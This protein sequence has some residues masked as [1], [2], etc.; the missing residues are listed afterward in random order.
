M[1][2][3]I[4]VRLLFTF[5]FVVA[6]TLSLRTVVSS[7]QF[8]VLVSRVTDPTNF[9]LVGMPP[10]HRGSTAQRRY[11]PPPRHTFPANFLSLGTICSKRLL[12]P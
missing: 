12:K 11:R 6:D 1:R 7:G 4:H 9:E 8:Y 5:E 3:V 10:Y 2:K